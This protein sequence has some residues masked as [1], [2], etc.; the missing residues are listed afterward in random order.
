[1][2]PK[3][4]SPRPRAKAD[5]VELVIPGRPEYVVVVRLAVAGIAGRMSFSYEDIEDLKLSV[6][7][8]CTSA[9][10][11][12]SPKVRVR[13]KISADR[14]EAEVSSTP[15]RRRRPSEER[16]LDILLVQCLMDEV[17]TE[18]DG[19]VHV[20]RMAKRVQTEPSGE[21]SAHKGTR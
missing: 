3:R 18:V 20:T 17:E 19:T 1:M 7:E 11:S 6:G 21:S 4:S 12:G 15:A 9:I 2:A 10:L 5:S 8:A 16:A 14:L 13:F